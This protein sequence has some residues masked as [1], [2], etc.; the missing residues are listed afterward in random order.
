MYVCHITA[1]KYMS[2]WKQHGAK[3]RQLGN[4]SSEVLVTCYYKKKVIYTKCTF[5]DIQPETPSHSFEAWRIAEQIAE[6]VAQVSRM[7][8]DKPHPIVQSSEDE[9]SSQM[10]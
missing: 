9:P 1:F 8:E 2:S 3:D 5:R 6:W 10:R 7:A 4:G